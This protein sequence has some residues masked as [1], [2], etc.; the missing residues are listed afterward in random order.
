M[1]IAFHTIDSEFLSERFGDRR[2]CFSPHNL[3]KTEPKNTRGA[4]ILIDRDNIQVR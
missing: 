2:V 1:N 4:H 3:A